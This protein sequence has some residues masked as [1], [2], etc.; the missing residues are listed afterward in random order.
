MSLDVLTPHPAK[1]VARVPIGLLV[2]GY[3]M[4]PI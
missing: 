4:Q 3:L 2:T 1:A